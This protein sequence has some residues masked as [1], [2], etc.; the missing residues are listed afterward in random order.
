MK[1]AV[2]SLFLIPGEVGGSETYL[3][4]T[5]RAMADAHPDIRL[6]LVTNREND[7]AMR[8]RFANFAN[9]SFHPLPL[10]ATNRYARIIAEQTALPHLLRTLKPDVLW[11]PGY[12]MP[13]W[14]PCPQVVSILD[15][16][17][18][19]HPDDLTRIAR[20]TTH[21]L[22]SMAV[23]RATRILAIS[24]FSRDEIV[25]ETGISG[26]R[27]RVTP[28][29]VDPIFAQPVGARAR[30]DMRRQALGG[31]LPF[32]LTVGH[33]YPHKNLALLVNAFRLIADEVPHHL[34][35][36]GKPRLGEPALKQAI[37]AAP[38]GRVHR[39]P[40]VSRA[41]LVAL[42]QACAAF[43]FPSLYEG[44]GL[45]L[46]EALAA[47]VPALATGAGATRDVGGNAA[48]YADG[49]DVRAWARAMVE[50]VRLDP[51][52]RAA[53]IEAGRAQA[54]RFTWARTADV[55][56]NAFREASG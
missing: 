31:D 15:M 50:L 12:T 39:I 45:P 9:C 46:L 24:E 27:I 21:A 17:Y 22:V 52:E 55:T 51:D 28:L 5:L 53:R 47:G 56:L 48:L 8:A 18:R 19:S 20:W 54:S 43:V 44:F 3:T 37:D 30:S 6:M 26:A 35:I 36:V 4:E 14:A 11:S 38:P 23:R 13:A 41:E 29:G 10:N 2:N 25:R 33:S 1:V 16:Q 7:A 32:L 49:R 40:A 42:Y 34:L